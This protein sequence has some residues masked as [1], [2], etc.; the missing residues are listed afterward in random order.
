MNDGIIKPT[1][2]LAAI[3]Q[4][5]LGNPTP[6]PLP[7]QAWHPEAVDWR[8]RVFKNGGI[9]SDATTKAVSV[10]CAAI[11]GAGLRDRFYRLN[12][13]CGNGISAALVPLYRGQVAGGAVVG[14]A[15]DTNNNFVSAD[16]NEMGNAC[17]LKADGTTKSLNTG[18]TVTP[19][20]FRNL[21]MGIGLRKTSTLAAGLRVAIGVYRPS[22]GRG[23]WI[24]ARRSDSDAVPNCA[25]GAYDTASNC[26]GD[27]VFTAAL[28]V[29]NIVA[30]FPVMS[31]K[32][33]ATGVAATTG[34]TTLTGVAPFHVFAQRNGDSGTIVDSHSDIR[35]DW[36]SIGLALSAAQAVLY[37]DALTAFQSALNRS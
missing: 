1:R 9:V 33:D 11:D 5:L 3:P 23:W 6:I 22:Q 34:N 17:G 32:G 37:N 19:F 10:F 27:P 36:Y 20:L 15:T 16:Y 7:D 35:A 8:V 18:V 31:R 2:Q 21:H 25:F 29:G 13:F 30:S 28:N 24:A 14:N 12:L 4:G 26:C